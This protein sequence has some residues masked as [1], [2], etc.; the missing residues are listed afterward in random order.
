YLPLPGSARQVGVSTPPGDATM[1]TT[2]TQ[3]PLPPS[4]QLVDKPAVAAML[5]ITPRCL[6]RWCA[7][8]YFP[9]PMKLGQ[10]SHKRLSCRWRL[11]DVLAWIE[12]HQAAA[13]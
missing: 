2:R 3:Q 12:Q 10:G 9:A 13:V 5:S 4:A 8:G 11:S 1:A 7:M 6:E